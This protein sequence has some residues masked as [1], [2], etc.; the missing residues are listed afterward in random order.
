[1]VEHNY[2]KTDQLFLHSSERE[3]NT[4]KYRASALSL[5]SRVS[6]YCPLAI[7]QLVQVHSFIDSPNDLVG[8]RQN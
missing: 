8:M 3:P 4:F 2:A 5:F 6:N 7:A 1:M